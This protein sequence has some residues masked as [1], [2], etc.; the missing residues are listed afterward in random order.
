MKKYVIIMMALSCGLFFSACNDWLEPKIENEI[1]ADKMYQ[2]GDGY[3]AVLNGLYK[4]MGKPSLYGR[5]LSFGFLDCLSQQY[6]LD[7]KTIPTYCSAAGF[8]YRDNDVK[9]IV[10]SQLPLT[11][12]R[13]GRKSGI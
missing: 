4:A 1:T 13:M 6:R 5:E 11:C 9:G 8:Q 2:S 10:E 3:R 12:L 7:E